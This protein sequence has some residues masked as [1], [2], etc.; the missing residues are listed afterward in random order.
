VLTAQALWVLGYAALPSFFVLYA[1]NQLG[2]RP[3]AA[4][5]M[6]VAFGVVC[7]AAMLIAGLERRPE[8]QTPLLAAGVL[9]MGGG[10]LAM[11]PAEKALDAAPGLM[12]AAVGFGMLSTLGFPVMARF[13]PEGEAG[14]Y[15]AAYFS[16]RSVAGAIALPA[17]GG[18]IAATGSYRSLVAFG[19]GVTLLALAPIAL[20][21]DRPTDAWRRWVPSPGRRAV[22]RAGALLGALTGSALAFGLI[23]E[24]LGPLDRLDGALFRSLNS[25]QGWFEVADDAI[26]GP[27]A[28]NYAILAAGALL[29]ALVWRRGREVR[30]LIAVSLSGLVAFGVVRLIWTIWDRDRPQERWAD[31]NLGGHD[32]APYPSFPSGHL[33]VWLAMSLAIAAAFP[34]VR[35]PLLAL[36]AAVALTRVAGGAHLPSDVVG[37]AFVGAGAWRITQTLL[38]RGYAAADVAAA[39][40]APAGGVPPGVTART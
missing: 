29:A 27:D 9:L 36:V 2:L 1:Q 26:I 30:I 24:H 10:L 6:L 28:R 20:L 38:D 12:C 14:A 15:T 19:G 5:G 39:P 35:I 17:A 23:A 25:T 32:W 16:I 33:A 31:V 37:A 3:S 21:A 18:I 7:G 4:G 34:R 11:T 8:R 13:I 40:C 22:L